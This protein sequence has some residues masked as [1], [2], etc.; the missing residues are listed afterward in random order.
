MI[1]YTKL[2]PLGSG[3]QGEVYKVV[4]RYNGNHHVCKIVV[5]KAEVPELRI[6][7]EKDFRARVE[8]EV[9]LVQE[10]KYVSSLMCLSAFVTLMITSG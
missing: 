5:V 4:D 6:Y 7:S 10:L 8:M 3:G 2:R 9:N 1:R